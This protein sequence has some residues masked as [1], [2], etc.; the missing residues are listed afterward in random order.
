VT[1]KEAATVTLLNLAR[2]DQAS[3]IMSTGAIA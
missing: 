3:T 2:H 1:F